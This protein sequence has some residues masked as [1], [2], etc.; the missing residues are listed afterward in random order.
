MDQNSL[1]KTYHGIN[2]SKGVALGKVFVYSPFVPIIDNAKISEDKVEEEISKFKLGQSRAVK[3]IEDI[4]DKL[5]KAHDKKADIFVAHKM[6]I[7]DPDMEEEIINSI[8]NK[9][10]ASKSI[11]EVIKKYKDMMLL[12]ECE[13]IRDKAYDL[14]DIENRI[15]RCILGF[16]EINLADIKEPVIVVTHDLTPSDTATLNKEMIKGIITEVGGQTSHSAIIARSYDIPAVLGVTD[17]LKHVN[18]GDKIILDAL[19]G[20]VIL[21]Y[22]ENL[23]KDFEKKQK[24]YLVELA[25]I[26]KYLDKE[27]ITKDGTN[28]SVNL[29]LAS[30][31]IEDLK[32]AKYVDGCG[33]FRTEFIFMGKQTL[34][35]EDEQFEI[36]KK[37]L[38]SFKGRVT[39]RT[40]DIGGDKKL[41]CMELPKEDNPFL[42]ERAL[43]LCLNHLD[44][45][46]TQL[47]AI[48]RASIYGKLNVMFPMVGTMD[49][50]TNAYKVVDEVK[51]ELDAKKIKYSKDIKVGIMIEIP[52]I[53]LISDI[54][55]KEVDFASIGTNDLCQY[56]L[57]VDRLNPNVSKYYQMYNPG[58][59]RLINYIV[60]SFNNN[61]KIVSV[62]GEMG[63]NPITAA[64]LIGFGMRTL[65][66]SASNLACVKK[67]IIN[68][69][70]EDLEKIS[71][72]VLTLKTND[73][74]KDYVTKHL[75]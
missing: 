57:A 9:N 47:K 27:P 2:V 63:G 59:L 7:L 21:N 35:T 41:D 50:V 62:C 75:K 10:S 67:M 19:K 52:S 14:S 45:F 36:Y 34:P 46:K 33:L 11:D 23:Y 4:V 66:M 44:I 49:D 13:C 30:T 39:I 28:I 53:G 3:E 20:D 74:I 69:S 29:N 15:L 70:I 56:S 48:F 24:C 6:L 73:E 32:N 54:V 31:K 72:K 16:E 37:V 68:N 12:N 43:R 71:K 38:L 5:T 22:D 40:L 26:K 51:K 55:S 58:V 60:T 25:D 8:K 64:I 65:S 1:V 42:G 17:I 18:N 61:K